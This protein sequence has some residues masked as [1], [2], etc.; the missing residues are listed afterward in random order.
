MHNKPKAE[1]KEIAQ[2]NLDN[3]Q[4]SMPVEWGHFGV[5]VQLL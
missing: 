5:Y 4:T 3:T 1:G 2:T